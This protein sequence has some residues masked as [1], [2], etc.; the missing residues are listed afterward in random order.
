M[1]GHGPATYDR[2]PEPDQAL[3]PLHRHPRRLVQRRAGRDRRA[4]SAPTAPASRRPCGSCRASCRPPAAPP[5]SPATTS[6]A[7]RWRCA[8]ASATCRRASP[9]TATC[10]WRRTW[11]SWPRSR[12][13]P[14]RR[15]ASAVADVMD[16]CL[17][18]DVQNRLI[19]NLSKGYRQ[20]VG[21]AQAIVSDPARADPRRAH[22]RAR[23]PADHRDPQPDQVAGR[24]AH[25]DPV[26]AHPPRG[27]DAVQRR[28]D[29][30]PRAAS[31]PRGRSTG[32]SS[33]SSRPRGWRSRWWGRPRRCRRACA[34]IAG[35]VRVDAVGRGGRRQP[36]RGR[37]GARAGRPR[38]DLPARRP[39]EVGPARAAAGGHDARRGVHPDRG[40]R[41]ERS[42]GAGAG[43]AGSRDGGDGG[44]E[45]VADL[46]EGAA[47][48]LHLAGGVRSS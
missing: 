4:S 27:L 15:A 9:S 8:G 35:V 33:S 39:A 42:G 29:H 14:A 30:Q 25:G 19:R 16:R 34:S 2:S 12:A 11:T 36:L 46:Q 28:G 48:V 6:S 47:A 13:C 5:A 17:I 38:R 21:L 32:W 3:R 44:R 24:R 1:T 43:A 7:S 41:G 22:H 40:R 23:P 18:A 37:V 20:R 26:H 10:G 31:W 45:G